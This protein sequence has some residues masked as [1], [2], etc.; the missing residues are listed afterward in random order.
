[1]G[2]IHCKLIGGFYYIHIGG[3]FNKPIGGFFLKLKFGLFIHFR[4]YQGVSSSTQKVHVLI[5]YIN[6]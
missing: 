2:G 5:F 1:M 6:D 3:F 4:V